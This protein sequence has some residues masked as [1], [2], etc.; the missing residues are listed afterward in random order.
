MLSCPGHRLSTPVTSHRLR[1]PLSSRRW[2]QNRF[3]FPLLTTE[4]HAKLPANCSALFCSTSHCTTS[5]L[6]TAPPAAIHHHACLPKLWGNTKQLPKPLA[7]AIDIR[8]A[9]PL[10]NPL[11]LSHRE[12]LHVHRCLRPRTAPLPPPRALLQC[13]ARHR[14]LRHPRWP[15][16]PAP[17]A[18][19]SP[20]SRTTVDS[21][22]WAPAD[23]APLPPLT[24]PRHR[25]MP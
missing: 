8:P 10:P 9:P 18:G 6:S 24:G 20:P 15:L 13:V 2:G 21:P 11:R 14:P 23:P 4:Y 16:V 19:F 7:G 5:P 3:C 1:T 12:C 25:L 22:G 17:D